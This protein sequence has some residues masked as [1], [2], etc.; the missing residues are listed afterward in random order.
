MSATILTL[1]GATIPELPRSWYFACRTRELPA[2]RP[3]TLRL[4]GHEIVVYRGASG[5][6]TAMDAKCAHL[7]AHLGRGVVAGDGLRCALHHR[8]H[9][10]GGACRESDRCRQPVYPAI[11]RYGAVFV[12]AGREPWFDFPSFDGEDGRLQMVIGRPTFVETSWPSITSN[13]FDI[14]HMQAV[15]QRTMRHPPEV[16]RLGDAGLQ[17]RYVSRV[18]GDGLSDRLMKYLSGD[19]I[20]VAVECWGGTLI[21]VRSEVGRLVSHLLLCVAPEASGSRVVPIFGVP[22]SRVAL[23]SHVRALASRWLFTAFLER[24]LVPLAGME[25]HPANALASSGPMAACTEWMLQLPR[26]VLREPLRGA[27]S[28][29]SEPMR[30]RRGDAFCS[31]NRA[32]S[33]LRDHRRS[34]DAADHG[35]PAE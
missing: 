27:A 23:A 11:E 34:G 17:V 26:A 24:D 6:V 15:H 2:G 3:M 33:R 14:E 10:P 25:L 16:T 29:R 5:R 31:G 13:A 20:R 8:V 19:M 22:R 4:A 28:A 21:G 30:E 32:G 1:C 9:Q 7:G 18:T 35:R 12:F